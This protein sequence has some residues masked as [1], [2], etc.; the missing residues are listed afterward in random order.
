MKELKKN[1]QEFEDLIKA[2][3]EAADERFRNQ[4]NQNEKYARE[5]EAESKAQSL[6]HEAAIKAL[7]KDHEQKMREIKSESK[8]V[9]KKAEEEFNVKMTKLEQEHAEEKKNADKEFEKAKQEGKEKIEKVEE[10]LKEIEKEQ[11]KELDL[12]LEKER[13]AQNE[14]MLAKKEL[15]QVIRNLKLENDQI[16]R[17][18]IEIEDKKRMEY[19]DKN[20]I[21]L[22]KTIDVENTKAIITEFERTTVPFI[23]VRGSLE[24]IRTLC[25]TAKDSEAFML[26]F[27]VDCDTENIPRQRNAFTSR[28]KT[29]NQYLLNTHTSDRDLL[30]KFFALIKKM[31]DLIN[32][33]DIIDIYTKLP[34]MVKDKNMKKIKEFGVEAENQFNL[35]TDVNKKVDSCL[36]EFITDY[37]HAS[38]RNPNDAIEQASTSTK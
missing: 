3:G 38:N 34:I 18:Q 16:R 23:S 8:E 29:Y 31:Q 33:S 25:D 5:R 20:I 22:V 15:N 14:H 28:V 26:T 12:F 9:Q 6:K 36:Q 17:Q 27:S 1:K 19:I 32:H 21:H 37:A 2:R 13:N 24:N 30:E 11:K 7:E 4:R 10:E 35:F